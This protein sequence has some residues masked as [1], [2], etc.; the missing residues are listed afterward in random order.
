[1][2]N[3]AVK[4]E[5]LTKYYK[6]NKALD[7]LTLEVA[8]G[9]VFSL[10][11]ANGAGKTTLMKLLL[12]IVKPTRGSAEILGT[13]ILDY[14]AR[15][16]IG[17]LNETHAFPN[18]LT[19]SQVLFYFGKM[20]N[21]S[22]SFIKKQIPV[23][24]KE[25]NLEKKGN[26]KIKKF[27]KGMSQRLG[28]AQALLN[29]PEILFLD[30]PTDGIDPVGRK[31]IRDILINLKNKG[32]TIFINSHLLSEVEK[33]SDDIAILKKGKLVKRGTVEE[34][35]KV[36]GHYEIALHK[37]ENR[38]YDEEVYK[39]LLLS[40]NI[41]IIG[42]KSEDV[43]SIEAYNIIKLN[44][45]IDIFKSSG[46]LIKSVIPSKISLEDFFINIIKE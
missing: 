15:K 39:S 38:I 33:I 45:A 10:L 13:D 24:L 11:G 6:K 26:I 7:G 22:T 17:Y 32:K 5:D 41:K 20:N 36:E 18:Y 46:Y 1:M 23:L 27:S 43:F 19:A 4:T 12:S 14:N 25:V 2:N 44:E 3:I 16:N 30:E 40:K 31:E 21:L 42:Q 8:K 28:I 35:V 9:S 34:F 29:N 37:I